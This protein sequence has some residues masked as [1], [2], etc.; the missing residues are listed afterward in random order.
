M[1][2]Q[3]PSTQNYCGKKQADTVNSRN[4]V[5]GYGWIRKVIGLQIPNTTLHHYTTIVFSIEQVEMI[6]SKTV[7][8]SIHYLNR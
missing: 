5:Y 1:F 8:P 4:Q 7:S 6:L 2:D 3:I